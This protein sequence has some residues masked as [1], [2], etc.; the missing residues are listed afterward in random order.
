ML[1]PNKIKLENGMTLLLI[2]NHQSPVVAFN[3]CFRVG[4]TVETAE[5]AGICHLIEHMI[6]KGTPTRAAGQIAA[7]IEA[8][9]GEINAYTSFDETVY[10]CTLSSRYFEEGLDI[11]SD[12]VLNPLFDETELAREKP[13]VLEEIKRSHDN[14]GKLL[15]ENLFALAYTQH[16]YGKPIIGYPETVKSFTRQKLLDFY[17]HWYVPENLVFVVS[18]DFDTGH[19]TRR[20]KEI[21]AKHSQQKA[22]RVSFPPEPAQTSPRLKVLRK[23]IE[24][25]YAQIAFPIPSMT[26]LDMPA[27]DV[28]SHLLGEGLSSRLEIQIKEKKS[29]VDSIYSYAY[30]PKHPGLFVVGFT[31]NEKKLL[32]AIEAILHEVSK[33]SQDKLTH[34][35]LARARLNIKSDSWYEKE[36]VEGLARKYGYFETQAYDCSFEEKYYQLIDEVDPEAVHEVAKKYLTPQKMNLAILLPQQSKL[37]EKD[38]SLEAWARALPPKLSSKKTEGIKKIKLKNGIRLLLQEKSHL[39]LVSIRLVNFGGLRLENAKNNGIHHLLARTLTKGTLKRSSEKLALSIEEIAG[40]IDAFS[41]KNLDGL[42]GDFLS[43]KIKEGLNLFTEVLLEPAFDPAEIEKE[44]RML[45]EG[46]KRENDQPA[47]LAYK[48]FFQELYPTHPYGM[49]VHGTLASVPNLSRTQLLQT[50]KALLDPSQM[51][52]GVVGDFDPDWICD[53]FE[54]KLGKLKKVSRSLPK[55]PQPVKLKSP[56]TVK[57]PQTK[58]QTHIA[59]GFLGT[60]LRSKDRYALDVLNNIL[61]GQGGRLFIE[62]RDKLSLAYSVTSFSQ[63]GLEAGYFSVYIATDPEREKEAI[64]GILRELQKIQTDLVSE[65]E[66]ERAQKYLAGSFEIDLQRS[67]NLASQMAFNEIYGLGAEEYQ[68]FP[69]KVFKVTREDVLKVAQKYLDLNSYVLSVVGKE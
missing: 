44:K 30:S 64:Q 4:S 25:L 66:L 15:A 24:G 55:L 26:S 53:F 62:L 50:H 38:F 1:K 28:L 8:A 27:L 22:P 9:G 23:E 56:L 46:I 67:S 12:A 34:A 63:E 42:Q 65:A 5:E 47:A 31:T 14:P 6:F 43:E 68:H 60:T 29:L 16:P 59:L 3:A 61:A 33:M 52:I 17:H 19:A 48:R 39:P 32:K 37:S 51:T 11:L 13:V 40:S 41:G 58:M 36:T 21:F 7:S 49:P 18:G 69:E 35:E 10:Y 45:I 57:L 54:N 2:E 20:I